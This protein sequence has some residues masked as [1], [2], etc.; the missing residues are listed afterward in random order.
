MENS[1]RRLS[2]G[3][4]NQWRQTLWIIP[5]NLADG[6]FDPNTACTGWHGVGSPA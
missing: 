4:H 6:I 5:E 3:A 2:A 1:L